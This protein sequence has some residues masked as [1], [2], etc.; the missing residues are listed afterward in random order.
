MPCPVCINPACGELRSTADPQGD[1]GLCALCRRAWF[2]YRLP[3]GGY[4][5]TTEVI[6]I[7]SKLRNEEFVKPPS[8]IAEFRAVEWMRTRH[9]AGHWDDRPLFS[10]HKL[11]NKTHWT[12]RLPHVLV[13][14][15]YAP[16]LRNLVEALVHYHLGRYVLGAGPGYAFYLAGAQYFGTRGLI[17][18][19]G[20]RNTVLDAR[21]REIRE[22]RGKTY[23]LTTG[24]YRSI[25]RRCIDALDRFN[26]ARNPLGQEM[27]DL[28]L[29]LHFEGVAA[30]DF[31]QA[32]VVHPGSIA[33][34]APADHPFCHWTPKNTWWA[35]QFA[36]KVRRGGG[37]IARQWPEGLDLSVDQ[38]IALRRKLNAQWGKMPF[39]P[40]ETLEADPGWLLES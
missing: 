14:R 31:H 22:V 6:R 26:I 13:G 40:E 36:N 39:D 28:I 19:P 15:R 25:G 10:L 16:R 7:A 24:D 9:S 18:P 8:S 33:T 37:T 12:R 29:G 30:G 5:P 20:Q 32:V 34:F 27:K 2:Q 35:P 38:K 1:I 3:T 21:T 17:R 11:F 4:F 23:H